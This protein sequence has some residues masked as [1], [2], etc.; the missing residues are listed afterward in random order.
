MLDFIEG[1][2]KTFSKT[3]RPLTNLLQ[4]EAVFNFDEKCLTA[5]NILKRAL[6]EVTIIK[7]PC[8]KPFELFFEAIHESMGAI[9]FH[10]DGDDLNIFH[11]ASRTLNGAQNNYPMVEK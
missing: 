10:Y 6:L 7:P 9:L 5:F 1:S 4:K 2:L 3:T 11:H 8:W